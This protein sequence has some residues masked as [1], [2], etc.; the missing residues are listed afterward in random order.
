[1]TKFK[2]FSGT[3]TGKSA[4]EKLNE[5]LE[6][7]RN[8]EIIDMKYQQARYG[9]HTICIMYK[10][11]MNH[12]KNSKLRSDDHFCPSMIACSVCGRTNRDNPDLRFGVT[13]F[14]VS[15][16]NGYICEDCSRK[17]K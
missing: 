13:P 5:W 2:I 11:K 4:D 8:I 6:S 17:V 16:L 10:E 9:D 7:N 1:M 14:G 12:Y 3:F 15:E